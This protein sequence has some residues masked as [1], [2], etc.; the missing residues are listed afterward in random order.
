MKLMCEYRQALERSDGFRPVRR[1][2]PDS[3]ADDAHGAKAQAVNV[4]LAADLEGAGMRCIGS[5]HDETL[6]IWKVTQD[7]RQ[8]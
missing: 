5:G 2:A 1:F 4:D 8:Q 3:A 6:W 7:E